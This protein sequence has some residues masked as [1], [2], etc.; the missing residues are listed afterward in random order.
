MRPTRNDSKFEKPKPF[1]KNVFTKN[2]KKLF[3][4]L[5]FEQLRNV[6]SSNSSNFFPLNKVQKLSRYQLLFFCLILGSILL[7]KP[8]NKNFSN[9]LLFRYKPNISSRFYNCFASNKLSTISILISALLDRYK[10]LYGIQWNELDQLSN[11]YRPN[12][13]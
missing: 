9:P 5:S 4:S 12:Y 10:T 7:Y 2:E 13:L 8:M 6:R 3:G 1:K 11:S